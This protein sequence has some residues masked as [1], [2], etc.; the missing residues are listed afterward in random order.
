MT[1]P[2]FSQLARGH[3][4]ARQRGKLGLDGGSD[5]AAEARVVGDQD[6]LR[7]CVVLGLGEEIGGDPGGIVVLIGDDHDL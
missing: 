2:K 4:R 5:G 1:A 3:A 7:R 6:R